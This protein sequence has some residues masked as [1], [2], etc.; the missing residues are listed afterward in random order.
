MSRVHACS[1]A[2]G[3]VV[4]VLLLVM[5]LATVRAAASV[6]ARS[7]SVSDP[8]NADYGNHVITTAVSSLHATISNVTVDPNP[9]EIDRFPL[10]ITG[11]QHS[12]ESES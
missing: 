6:V 12:L 3:A 8:R 10:R 11:L 4:N 2:V 9:A 1:N 7:D 5:L